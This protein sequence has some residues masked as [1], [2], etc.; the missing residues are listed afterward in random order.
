MEDKRSAADLAKNAGISESEI[1]K[2]V[3]SLIDEELAVRTED[4]LIERKNDAVSFFLTFLSMA[5]VHLGHTKG[6]STDV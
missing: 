5:I 2:A 4:N 3:T 6:I 1:D